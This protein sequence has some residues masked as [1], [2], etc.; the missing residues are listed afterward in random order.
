M[1]VFIDKSK[2]FPQYIPDT[3]PHREDK[4]DL[5]YS[6]FDEFFIKPS[7]VYCKPIQ[8]IG[9]VGTGKTSVAWVFGS[10]MSDKASKLKLNLKPIFVNCKIEGTTRYYLYS[11]LLERVTGAMPRG[12]G[13]EEM[14][15]SFINYINRNDIYVLLILDEIDYLV[16][17][18][19]ETTKEKG[20]IYDLTRLSEVQIGEYQNVIGLILISRSMDYM[21][22]L[23]PS[24]ISTLG[25]TIIRLDPYNEKELFD[26]LDMRCQL[27]FRKGAVDQEAIEFIA[28][29]TATKDINPGD[30]RFAL[31]ILLY[32]GLIAER[33]GYD[34]V[35]ID[36]VRRALSQTLSGIRSEDLIGMD[37]SYIIT[38]LSIARAL[39]TSK[40]PFIS[41][42]QAYQY[43]KIICEEKNLTPVKSEKF[44]DI[45]NDLK[46][47]DMIKV[48]EKGITILEAS[49]KEIEERLEHILRRLKI[50]SE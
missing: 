36:H 6:F 39:R 29:I 5:L 48:S 41:I 26:I 30:A 3:L 4:I 12:M 9:P 16:L 33:E 32:S 46:Y 42:S 10:R 22:V 14:L 8:I 19:R 45:V 1:S 25:S 37:E 24:E 11:T 28:E 27:A 15:K 20:V 47:R 44:K 23:D 34:R 21:K 2:L 38:L 7:Q 50:V 40:E 18:E 49:P 35:T 13:P 31:D 43:Y 17:K